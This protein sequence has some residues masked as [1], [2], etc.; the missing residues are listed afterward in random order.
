MYPRIHLSLRV[1]D[2]SRSTDFYRNLLD[3]APDKVK[4]G[5]TRFM[6][7]TTPILLSLIQDAA[8]TTGG[9]IDHLGIRL[10]GP[11]AVNAI[12]RRLEALGVEM[13]LEEGV[14]CCWAVQNKVWLT[15]PDGHRWEIY[16]VTD[17]QTVAV[18]DVACCAPT[19][20]DTFC[21]EPEPTPSGGCCG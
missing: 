15:D 9:R 16:T 21:C 3:E 17:E 2:M 4:P 6:P 13:E 10:D 8:A 19:V 11:A 14:T 18:E 1:S 12:R 5:Y 7:A 20:A